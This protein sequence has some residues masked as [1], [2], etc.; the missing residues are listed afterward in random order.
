M[1]NTTLSEINLFSSVSSD[2]TAL[3]SS[4]S[5]QS[6]ITVPFHMLSHKLEGWPNEILTFQSKKKIYKVY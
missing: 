4:S 3:G 1:Q 6:E 5:C 2:A